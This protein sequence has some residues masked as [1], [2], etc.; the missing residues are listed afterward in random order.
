MEKE[1]K[2]CVAKGATIDYYVKLL[3]SGEIIDTALDIKAK[4][5]KLVSTG[6]PNEV[7]VLI[8]EIE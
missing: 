1:H 3:V 2:F 4:V 5:S 8:K 6:K 7:L